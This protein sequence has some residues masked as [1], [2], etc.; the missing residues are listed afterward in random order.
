MIWAAVS[1]DRWGTLSNLLADVLIVAATTVA[2]QQWR[3]RRQRRKVCDEIVKAV[4]IGREHFGSI[5][6]ECRQVSEWSAQH[7]TAADDEHWPW[8]MIRRL[9]YVGLAEDHFSPWLRLHESFEDFAAEFGIVDF[10]RFLLRAEPVHQRMRHHLH[11]AESTLARPWPRPKRSA[12]LMTPSAPDQDESQ[13]S[14]DPAEVSAAL[15]Q[16]ASTAE[17]LRDALEPV[18]GALTTIDPKATASQL[19]PDAIPPPISVLATVLAVIAGTVWVL[20]YLGSETR[21][22]ATGLTDNVLAGLVVVLVGLGIAELTVQWEWERRIRLCIPYAREVSKT[23]LTVH[24]A[25]HWPDTEQRMEA[26]SAIAASMDACAGPLQHIKA[27]ARFQGYV[28]LFAKRVE[29]CVARGA[30]T[31]KFSAIPGTLTSTLDGNSEVVTLYPPTPVG[32]RLVQLAGR[33]LSRANEVY[34]RRS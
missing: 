29:Q 9:P 2:I 20:S 26:L 34:L 11:Q 25:V 14:Y 21:E 12:S 22:F 16:L 31:A 1:I 6:D 23:A 4:L 30:D 3:V 13:Q 24:A 28:E 27:D 17:E 18:R 33:I 8:Q 19:V 15:T 10:S 32:N 5:E 7:P